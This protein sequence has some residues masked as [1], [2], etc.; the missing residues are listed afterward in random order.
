MVGIDFTGCDQHLIKQTFG[1]VYHTFAKV[2]G[3]GGVVES[4]LNNP[5]FINRQNFAGQGYCNEALCDPS[6]WNGLCAVSESG[7]QGIG[8]SLLRDNLLRNYCTMIEIVDATEQTVNNVFMYAPYRLISVIRSEAKLLNTSAD[9]VGFG[10]VYHVCDGSCVTVVN[11]LRSAGDSIECDES[12]ALDVYNRINTEIYF[13]GNYHSLSGR[14]DSDAFGFVMV[15]REP[16]DVKKNTHSVRYAEFH[17][18]PIYSK[19][20]NGFSYCHTAIPIPEQPI[21]ILLELDLVPMDVSHYVNRDGYLHLWVWVEDLSSQLWGGNIQLSSSGCADIDCLLW[22]T[23]SYLTHTEWNEVWLSLADAKKR[24]NFNPTAANFF[25]V[26]TIHNPQR[27]HGHVYFSDICL[28]TA[29]SDN[30]RKPI[31]F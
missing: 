28:C 3:C 13:E 11:A 30:I 7:T 22:V 27:N 18:D 10:S 5:H 8:F 12:S 21:D 31:D 24:G 25:R 26:A 17:D 9:F 15:D 29:K 16:L 6:A 19:S 2:G 14:Y 20:G 23:T 1:C 4:C